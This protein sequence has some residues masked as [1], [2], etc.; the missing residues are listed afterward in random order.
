MIKVLTVKLLG[1]AKEVAGINWEL[2]CLARI[3]WKLLCLA[4][5][6]WELLFLALHLGV[7]YGHST[8]QTLGH[9]EEPWIPWID[10]GTRN[11]LAR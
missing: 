5:I 9:H 11:I 8:R 2:L 4:S 3:N 10:A 6:S 1:Y 7:H